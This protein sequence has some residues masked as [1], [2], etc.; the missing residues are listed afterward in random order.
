M[1]LVNTIV[2][3]LILSIFHSVIVIFLIFPYKNVAFSKILNV[4]PS[5]SN[6]KNY[7]KA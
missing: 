4:F 5:L 1:L 2:F 6:K 3:I 7:C